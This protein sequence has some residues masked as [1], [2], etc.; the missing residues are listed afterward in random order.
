MFWCFD[1]IR[2]GRPPVSTSNAWKNWMGMYISLNEWTFFLVI[3]IDFTL[4]IK[5]E[6]TLG[7]VSLFWRPEKKFVYIHYIIHSYM[8][9]QFFHALPVYIYLHK[10][11]RI[12][13][14]NLEMVTLRRRIAVDKS[15][16]A[17]HGFQT[18]QADWCSQA[19]ALDF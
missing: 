19:I 16:Q 14:A 10:F 13:F 2:Y 12:T 7:E 6:N 18:G 9:I 17:L 3:K 1:F 8:H 15:A 11:V 5:N 4:L